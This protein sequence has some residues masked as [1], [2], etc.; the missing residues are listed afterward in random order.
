MRQESVLF[1]YGGKEK[2]GEK[3]SI[4]ELGNWK[5]VQ[6]QIILIFLFPPVRELDKFC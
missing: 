5:I 1:F 2:V 6:I 4:Y 3:G